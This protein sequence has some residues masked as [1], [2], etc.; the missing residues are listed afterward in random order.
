MLANKALVVVA[1][2]YKQKKKILLKLKN[3]TKS[4]ATKKKEKKEA[5][6]RL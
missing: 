3:P 1:Q 2:A 4:D 6:M 5:K